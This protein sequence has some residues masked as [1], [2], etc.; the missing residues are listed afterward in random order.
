VIEK[1]KTVIEKRDIINFLF[2]VSFPVYGIGTY[3]AASVN[4]SV[5]YFI[6]ISP[7]IL[8]I[9]FYFIDLLYKKTFS[10]RLNA[11]YFLMLLFQLSCIVSLFIALSNNL[12]ESTLH[13]TV[14]R[15]ISLITPFHAFIVVALYN[16]HD[17]SQLPRLTL[18]SLSLLLAINLLAYYGLGW[19][20]AFHNIEGRLSLPFFDGLYSG[21]NTI[22]I[23]NLILLYYLVRSWRN[24]ILFICLLAYFIFNFALFYMINS[25]LSMLIFLFVITLILTKSVRAKVIFP[26]SMVTIPILLSSG[27]L[28]YQILQHPLFVSL[29]QR[30]D[31]IDVTTFNGRAFLWQDAIDWLVNDQ[32]GLLFGNGYKGHYFL[33]LVPDVV[34]LW[35]A[36]DSHHL[37]LHSTSLETLVCQGVVFFILLCVIF[38]ITYGYYRRGHKEGSEQ[39]SF[40]PVVIFLLFIM[41]VDTFVYLDS[42]GWVI[43]ALL[44]SRTVINERVKVV[45]SVGLRDLSAIGYSESPLSRSVHFDRRRSS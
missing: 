13:L 44:M 4:P 33:D 24:A 34:K 37:H 25:R 28:L 22:A 16:D 6:S 20:N 45:G 3:I 40:F 8:I 23:I 11:A 29:V 31:I 15:S 27:F 10:I 30:V 14:G 18:L 9:T 35:N 21:A 2:V 43:F 5:G 38:Y 7:H 19:S 42:L 17:E 32:R 36:E 41:Q 39:G 12:P 26:L 1:Y